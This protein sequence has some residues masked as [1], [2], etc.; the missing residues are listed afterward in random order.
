MEAF[1]WLEAA[2]QDHRGVTSLSHLDAGYQPIAL[3]ECARR[4]FEIVQKAKAPG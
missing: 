1:A 3:S 2:R 4:S